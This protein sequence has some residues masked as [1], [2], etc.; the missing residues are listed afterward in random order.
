MQRKFLT[1]KTVHTDADCSASAL[2]F[3]VY[4]GYASFFVRPIVANCLLTCHAAV[5]RHRLLFAWET[6][7]TLRQRDASYL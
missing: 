1:A 5:D 3:C 6:P 4:T 2:L 7:V